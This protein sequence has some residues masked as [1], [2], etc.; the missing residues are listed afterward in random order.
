MSI[1]MSRSKSNN[2]NSSKNSSKSSNITTITS[3]NITNRSNGN[4]SCNNSIRS[5]SNNNNINSNGND[6]WNEISYN[7]VSKRVVLWA[8][9]YGGLCP[10]DLC[11]PDPP[12]PFP[13]PIPASSACSSSLVPSP[14]GSVSWFVG[15]LSFSCRCYL[16]LGALMFSGVGWGCF[17]RPW[18]R[19]WAI[20]VR[21]R[22]LPWRLL[23]L[24]VGVTY[25]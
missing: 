18:T 13:P 17:W 24:V 21:G 9:P 23:V 22:G 4:I 19:V 6:K 1:S 5:N 8:R 20:L 15:P 25:M 2:I 16:V 12:N 7:T 14:L 3:S 10:L 11:R